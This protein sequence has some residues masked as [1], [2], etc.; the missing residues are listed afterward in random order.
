MKATR[1]WSPD[2]AFLAFGRLPWLEAGSWGAVAIQIVNVKT[3]QVTILPGSDGL[4]SPHWSPD[5]RYLL[6]V[7]ATEP[8]DT[9]KLFDFDK[10]TWQA[11]TD[12][13]A[14]Y[15]N[16]SADGQYVHFINPYVAVPQL[17]RFRAPDGKIERIAAL[18]PQQLGWTIVGKWTGLAGDDSPPVLPILGVSTT[19]CRS[20]V[21][22]AV[23]PNPSE[24]EWTP[25]G[26]SPV[27]S[28]TL[29]SWP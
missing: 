28:P 12:I 3:R 9:L 18:D 8:G 27:T 2:G 7:A 22:S 5:G 15:P 24:P 21:I 10:R 17:Y 6:S 1:V 25:P 26:P 20:A 19:P 14:A 29:Q 4:F 16:W 13:P 11:L 23:G